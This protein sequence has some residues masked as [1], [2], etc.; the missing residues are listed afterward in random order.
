MSK[1][2]KFLIAFSLLLCFMLVVFN[3]HA[4]ELVQ[5][6][7]AQTEQSLTKTATVTSMTYHSLP[8]YKSTNNKLFVV[9]LSKNGGY[10]KVYLEKKK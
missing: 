8:V 5:K 10:Y 7:K 3:S 2:H 4:Q 6:A 9:K 1:A